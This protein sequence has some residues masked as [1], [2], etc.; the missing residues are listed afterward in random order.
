L[1]GD[2]EDNGFEKMA[3]REDGSNGET[4]LTVPIGDGQRGF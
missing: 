2:N 4:A 3:G 1:S